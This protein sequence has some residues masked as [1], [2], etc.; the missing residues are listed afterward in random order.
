MLEAVGTLVEFTDNRSFRHFQQKAASPTL[1]LGGFR[2]EKGYFGANVLKT[3]VKTFTAI[4]ISFS[5]RLSSRKKASCSTF[6]FSVNG[7]S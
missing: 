4:W 1:G 6:S 7:L 2:Y 3:S 5:F